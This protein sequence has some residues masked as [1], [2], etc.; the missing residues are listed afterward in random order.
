M[1]WGCAQYTKELPYANHAIKYN[2]KP[3]EPG[4]LVLEFY[5]TPFD[6]AGCEGPERAVESVLTENKLIGLSWAVIAYDDP[7]LQQAPFLEPL[8]QA[9]LLRQCVRPGRLPPDAAGAAVPQ[10]H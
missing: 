5:I 1:D 2:F 9:D 6:Y 8:S 4:K 10:T 7:E 3:G